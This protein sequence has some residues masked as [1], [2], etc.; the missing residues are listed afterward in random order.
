M[1]GE[2]DGRGLQVEQLRQAL[3][4]ARARLESER[5]TAVAV[6]RAASEE[7][8]SARPRRAWRLVVPAATLAV[9]MVLGFALGSARAGREPAGAAAA[10]PPTTRPAPPTSVVV[11]PSA[12]PACLE[13]ATRGDRLIELLVT[14]QRDKVADLLVAYTVASRQCRRDASP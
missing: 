2:Q 4:S 3:L 7:T 10:R 6:D 5:L 13:T 12:S 11:R 1:E 8:G 9:G 14:N